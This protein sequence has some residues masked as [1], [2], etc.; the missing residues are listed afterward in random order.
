VGEVSEA[1]SQS[2]L[3][4]SPVLTFSP[5]RSRRDSEGVVEGMTQ[6]ERGVEDGAMGARDCAPT[7]RRERADKG[8][9]PR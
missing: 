2:F 6:A 7:I 9:V 3:A 1:Q 4:V 5:E 8:N